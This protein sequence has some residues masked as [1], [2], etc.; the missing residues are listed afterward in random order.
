MEQA[1][2]TIPG[3]TVHIGHSIKAWMGCV[4]LTASWLARHLACD[5]TNIYKLFH[6]RSVDSN[7]LMKVSLALHHD[8][9]ALYTTAYNEALR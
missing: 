7:T 6:R 2:M 5:R 9:F 1:G 8:F 4:E 3:A